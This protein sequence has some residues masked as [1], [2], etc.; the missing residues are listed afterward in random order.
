M[1]LWTKT[2][3]NHA[4]GRKYEYFFQLS[5][6]KN[7]LYENPQVTKVIKYLRERYGEPATRESVNHPQ[8]GKPYMNRMIPNPNWWI[9]HNHRRIYVT[10]GTT[11]TMMAL[12]IG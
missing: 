12:A 5:R 10:Q 8:T 4:H 7:Y 9:D 3:G 1:L 11:L 6:R 2:T